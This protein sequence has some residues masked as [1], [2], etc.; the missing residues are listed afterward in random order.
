MERR[1]CSSRELVVFNS[2]DCCNRASLP[3]QYID[4]AGLGSG[5]YRSQLTANA[6]NQFTESDS[7][8]GNGSEVAGDDCDPGNSGGHNNGGDF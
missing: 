8:R 5:P 4:L 7:G 2:R 6:L 1:C 3:D